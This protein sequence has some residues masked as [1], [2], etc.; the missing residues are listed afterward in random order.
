MFF[1]F[2]VGMSA[3]LV[4]YAVI[5][6]STY[7]YV[8]TI[9]SLYLWDRPQVS[10]LETFPFYREWNKGSKERQRPIQGLHFTEVSVLSSGLLFIDKVM[11][12]INSLW[13][14]SV[15]GD[16]SW[17]LNI[18]KL[19]DLQQERIMGKEGKAQSSPWDELIGS[20]FHERSANFY[21][22]VVITV[23]FSFWGRRGWGLDVVLKNWLKSVDIPGIKLPLKYNIKK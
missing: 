1:D 4:R 9:N 11:S 14:T 8:S 5:I 10:V 18:G 23:F 3:I 20:C 16:Q 22:T 13:V 17:V 15:H 6:I 19:C 21:S 2:F 7:F 12:S